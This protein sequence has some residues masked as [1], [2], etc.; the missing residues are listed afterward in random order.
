MMNAV[1]L[2]YLHSGYP[3]HRRAAEAYIALLNQVTMLVP[4][5]A[6]ADI[7]V[8]HD[9]PHRY[10]RY[11]KDIGCLPHKHVIGYAVWEASVLP[12]AYVDG[13]S[14]VDEIW[15]CSK[16]CEVAFAKYHSNVKV[17]PHVMEP[18]YVGAGAHTRRAADRMLSGSCVTFLSV[19]RLIDRRK[20]VDG[21]LEAFA[22]TASELVDARLVLKLRSGD[23]LETKDNRVVAVADFFIRRGDGLSVW[24]RRLLHWRSSFGGMGLLFV[25]C[26][27]IGSPRYSHKLVGKPRLYELR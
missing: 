4:D 26:D 3:S 16:Y 20:N 27:A 14:L 2:C 18:K 19:A 21:L 23:S 15:T 1:K 17:V 11:F 8:I 5:P 24:Q 25:R 7:V 6:S 10:A 13:I 12:R 22:M 9:E